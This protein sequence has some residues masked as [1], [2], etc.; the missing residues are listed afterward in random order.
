[1]CVNPKTKAEWIL[2]MFSASALNTDVQVAW[3]S[4]CTCG[5]FL[6]LFFFERA[7]SIPAV[8]CQGAFFSLCD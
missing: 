3:F 8:S 6:N 4:L 7:R 2:M 1:M 5:L